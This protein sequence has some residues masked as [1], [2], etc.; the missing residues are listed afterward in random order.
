MVQVKERAG[1]GDA[2]KG[3]QG[4]LSKIEVKEGETQHLRNP[5]ILYNIFDCPCLSP[6]FLSRE[7][8]SRVLP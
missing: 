5:S 7:R 1:K 3:Q 8:I 4:G 6:R 2:S